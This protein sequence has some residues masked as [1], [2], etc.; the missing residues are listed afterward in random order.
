MASELGNW[1]G[2]DSVLPKQRTGSNFQPV[3]MAMFDHS[4]SKRSISVLFPLITNHH[5]LVV[6]F[7]EFLNFRLMEKLGPREEGVVCLMALITTVVNVDLRVPQTF[8]KFS[9][10]T[11]FLVAWGAWLVVGVETWASLGSLNARL[12]P[13]QFRSLYPSPFLFSPLCSMVLHSLSP[14][15]AN[16]EPLPLLTRWHCCCRSRKQ[17]QAQLAA[18]PL[19]HAGRRL[20]IEVR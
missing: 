1:A 11:R 19:A 15:Q 12:Y 10:G 2:V 7:W 14:C 3:C 8:L 9:T 16:V 18:L 6:Q 17:R 13:F 20:Q 4:L 5:F